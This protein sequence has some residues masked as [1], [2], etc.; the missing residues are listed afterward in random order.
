MDEYRCQYK[1]NN[2][3]YQL[4]DKKLLPL[5]M[6]IVSSRPS[7]SKS[8][9]EDVLSKRIE[10]LGF[11]EKEIMKYIDHFPFS[12]SFSKCIN[13]TNSQSVQ[14]SPKE[15]LHSHPNVM[16]MCYL[17]VHSAMIC[18]LYDSESFSQ[19]SIQTSIYKKF[20]RSQILCHLTLSFP[21]PLKSG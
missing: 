17:P 9:R 3:I 19:L 21:I 7:A 11:T 10:V 20:T 14:D 13:A 2:V 8:V 12:S 5:A 4:L 18:Y 16:D 15:Y 6:I 1:E